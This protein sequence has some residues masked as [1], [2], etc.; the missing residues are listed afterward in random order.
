LLQKEAVVGALSDETLK[1]FHLLYLERM[2]NKP[3][4]I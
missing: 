2:G 3:I 4:E 1:A